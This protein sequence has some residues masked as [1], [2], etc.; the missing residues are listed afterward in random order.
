MS[1]IT[2]TTINSGITLGTSGSYVSPLTIAWDG[3][4]EASS[5]D[6]IYGNNTQA[7]TVV[8]DDTV[9][10]GSGGYGIN[11]RRG[12]S[13]DNT[14]TGLIEGATRGSSWAALARSAPRRAR[15]RLPRRRSHHRWTDGQARLPDNWLRAFPGVVTLE[16][17]LIPS[18]LPYRLPAPAAISTRQPKRSLSKRPRRRRSAA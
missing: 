8:N 14:G 17:H 9:A 10:T 7:W 13:V 6:A 1:M 15:R 4:V 11:L 3:A 2:G 5:G 18:C 16:V 12:G